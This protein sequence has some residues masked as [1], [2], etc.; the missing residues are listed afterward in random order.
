MNL[1]FLLFNDS[2]DAHYF[3]AL[4]NTKMWYENFNALLMYYE[5]VNMLQTHV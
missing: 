1:Q 5:L 3:M 4:K 2:E